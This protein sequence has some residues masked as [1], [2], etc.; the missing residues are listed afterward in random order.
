MY[1]NKIKFCDT[2]PLNI[3]GEWLQYREIIGEIQ[4]GESVSWE[5][6]CPGILWSGEYIII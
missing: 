2:T 1:G 6:G 5:T 3:R 4:R